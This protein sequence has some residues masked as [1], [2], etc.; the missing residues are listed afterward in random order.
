M[1]VFICFIFPLILFCSKPPILS[2]YLIDLRV[3]D[4]KITNVLDIQFLHGYYEPTIFI[5]YE[6]LQTWS[7]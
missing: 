5:L 4:E 1:L 7:G 3:M 6:P 2:S